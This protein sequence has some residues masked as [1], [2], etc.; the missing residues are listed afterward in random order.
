MST[1]DRLT[2]VLDLAGNTLYEFH[3]GT[4]F[5]QPHERP[6]ATQAVPGRDRGRDP[7][8]DRPNPLAKADIAWTWIVPGYKPAEPARAHWSAVNDGVQRAFGWRGTVLLQKR[9]AAD[10]VLVCEAKYLG[11]DRPLT[12]EQMVKG[13]FTVRFEQREAWRPLEVAGIVRWGTA[14]FVWGQS[15]W[16]G[17]GETYAIP[18]GYAYRY[19]TLTNGGTEPELAAVYTLNGPLAGPVTLYNT[20]ADV[21]GMPVPPGLSPRTMYFQFMP[22][23]AVGEYATFDSGTGAITTNKAGVV[24]WAV[25]L[26]GAGQA[27]HMALPPG[28]N[29]MLLRC[30][31]ASGGG[32]V[33][34]AAYD[35]FA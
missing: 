32:A 17:S 31:T 19:F 23:L 9:T 8:G 6:S 16:G 4:G 24:G 15:N 22:S 18:G 26:R 7:R 34:V 12:T 13:E 20:S 5:T 35:R 10:L 11:M 25:S 14:S 3:N 1:V 21:Y 29:A 27:V 33:S 28:D 2:A 30:P